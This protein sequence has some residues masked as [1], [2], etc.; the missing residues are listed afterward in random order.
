VRIAL[1]SVLP[2]APQFEHIEKLVALITAPNRSQTDPLPGGTI[3][4]VMGNWIWLQSLA[5]G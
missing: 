5:S 4:G 2:V 3:A 1:Q